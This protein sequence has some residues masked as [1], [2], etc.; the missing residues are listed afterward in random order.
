M[1]VQ[2]FI[3]AE[4]EKQAKIEHAPRIA[5]EEAWLEENGKRKEV[6][7]TPSGL[8][9]EILRQG[10]GA[11]PSDTSKVKVH[12]HGTLLNGTVFDSSVDRGEP[13]VFGVNQVIAGWTEALQLM[14]VGSK[15]KLYIPYQLAYG[16]RDMGKIPPYSMLIFEVELLNIE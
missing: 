16:S 2:A 5:E 10:K 6:T 7:V 13:I 15:W 11:L 9:Y 4:R 1:Y 3:T 12:Y 14:P 8:Q